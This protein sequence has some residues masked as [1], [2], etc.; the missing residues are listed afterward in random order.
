MSPALDSNPTLDQQA[1]SQHA[2]AADLQQWLAAEIEDHDDLEEAVE[3][4]Q[5]FQQEHPLFTRAAD[6]L[7]VRFADELEAHIAAWLRRSAAGEFD[8]PGA[9]AG[10][11]EHVWRELL[12]AVVQRRLEGTRDLVFDAVLEVVN[13]QFAL[14]HDGLAAKPLDSLGLLA[15]LAVIRRHAKE[16]D[17][18]LTRLQA[19]LAPT[20]TEE[21]RAL[22]DELEGLAPALA[23]AHARC[24]TLND[25]R[26]TQIEELAPDAVRAVAVGSEQDQ[27]AELGAELDW[28]KSLKRQATQ[29]VTVM[30][31]RLNDSDINNLQRLAGSLSLST[32]LRGQRFVVFAATAI[33]TRQLGG[34]SLTPF[35]ECKYA[36]YDFIRVLCLLGGISDY[37]ADESHVT[38]AEGLRAFPEEVLRTLWPFTPF[39]QPAILR[40]LDLHPAEALRSAIV[41]VSGVRSTDPWQGCAGSFPEE[42]E[43]AAAA[44]ARIRDTAAAID[45]ALV[46]RFYDFALGAKWWLKDTLKFVGAV[47]GHNRAELESL[48]KRHAQAALKT[49]GLLPVTS[50]DDALARYQLLEAAIVEARRYGAERSANT[51]DAARIGL[52]HLARSVESAGGGR[53]EWLLEARRAATTQS[54]LG[55]SFQDGPYTL[56]LGLDGADAQ[57]LI[58]KD[59][60]ALKAVP[61]AIKKGKYAEL[62]EAQI[63]LR[64]QGRRLRSALE[65]CMVEGTPLDADDFNTIFSLATGAVLLKTLLL[66]D[67]D[68]RFGLPTGIGSELRG[69]A[70]SR[71]EGSAPFTL[72]HVQALFEAQQLSAW[73]RE[74]VRL[75][76]VQPFKQVFRE[77]YVP[78]PAELDAGT[79]SQRYAGRVLTANTVARLLIGRGWK[80]AGGDDVTVTRAQGGSGLRA[81]LMIPDAYHYL[82]NDPQCTL[83]EVRFERGNKLIA[84][85][86]VP[87][88]F[89]SEIMRDIDLIVAVAATSDDHR[90]VS[91][92]SIAVRAATLSE[93]CVRLGVRNVSF[94]APYC[95]V[96]GKRASYRI[97]LGSGVIHIV[98]G[99]YL[100]IIAEPGRKAAGV[101][102]PFADADER[103]SEILSKLLLLAEDHKIKDATILKQIEQS[104]AAE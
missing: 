23:E 41:A 11:A 55:Q 52:T 97:H 8:A 50:I 30:A 3:A 1:A 101:L 75:G 103:C 18:L 24:G 90:P 66:R 47:L 63:A 15:R 40:A 53:L 64:D 49:Y 67:R 79:H 60:K 43:A 2:R 44:A 86:E 37:E 42:A 39:A 26:Y 31:Q 36:D 33:A 7:K 68:G 25:P 17:G 29:G 87:P 51:R 77:L 100:C 12:V 6:A 13:A 21:R 10:F 82:G 89:F 69:I 80:I 96:Q 20:T 4:A 9:G 74:I 73:Q 54:L 27:A 16:L 72:V 34:R 61:A 59:G 88:V 104:V 35:A 5:R 71:F 102:L 95:Y 22:S 32:R 94:S 46:K 56:A 85:G 92:E 65:R 28:R 58:E 99:S 91:S 84:L 83:A 38:L 57:I 62:R 70:D 78:T 93:L 81:Q 76:M 98:P 14:A 48:I 45:A 19:L